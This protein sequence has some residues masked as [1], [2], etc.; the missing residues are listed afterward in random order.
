MVRRV[1]LSFVEEDLGIV[2]LFRGQAKNPNNPLE[3]YDYSVKEPFD[4]NRSEY[5]K[6]QI[7]GLINNSSVLLCLI[8]STTST[9]R[10]VD[11]EIKTAYELKKGVAGVKLHSSSSDV[12]P[13]GLSSHSTEVVNWGT[14]QIM[15]AIERAAKKAGF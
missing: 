6:Q 9:S 14:Q 12:I 7:K 4:S 3:F 1:F 2:N 13:Q 8:G 11:W 10:W 15:D 5:V